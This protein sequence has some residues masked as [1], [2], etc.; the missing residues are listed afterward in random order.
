MRITKEEKFLYEMG[1]YLEK[2][3][4]EKEEGVDPQ[5]IAAMCKVGKKALTNLLNRLRRG[6]Y[7]LLGEKE[8]CYN[9]SIHGW[10]TYEHLLKELFS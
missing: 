9:L 4:D 7:I 2:F 3:P 6:N 5:A 8:G 1:R 10:Q